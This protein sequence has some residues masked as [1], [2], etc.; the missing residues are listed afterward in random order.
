MHEQFLGPWM[1]IQGFGKVSLTGDI[2]EKMGRDIKDI[3]SQGPCLDELAY[4]MQQIS[5][6]ANKCYDRGE[7]EAAQYQWVYMQAYWLFSSGMT[8]IRKKYARVDHFKATIKPITQTMFRL[9]L[10]H[11]ANQEYRRAEGDAE[12]ILDWSEHYSSLKDPLEPVFKAKVQLC[13]LFSLTA[14]PRCSHK[15]ERGALNRVVT[16]LLRS[17][18]FADRNFKQLHNEVR[19]GIDNSLIKLGCRHRCGRKNLACD[20]SKGGRD[21]EIRPECRSFWD[22]LDVPEEQ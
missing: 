22:W 14:S 5:R 3:I 16:S 1:H 10:L 12:H 21:W 6:K 4:Q 18:L 15:V 13:R 8:V 11:I 17:P 2:S 19:L 7:I 9:V 20:V